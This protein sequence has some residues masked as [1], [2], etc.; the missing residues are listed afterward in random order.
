MEKKQNFK[1]RLIEFLFDRRSKKLFSAPRFNSCLLCFKTI[2]PFNTFPDAKWADRHIQLT[3]RAD[4]RLFSF[5]FGFAHFYM[6]VESWGLNV[7]LISI[8]VTI[9]LK[10]CLK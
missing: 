3:S 9:L 7:F 2:S 6:K 1:I 10:Y 4:V 8:S 5:Y